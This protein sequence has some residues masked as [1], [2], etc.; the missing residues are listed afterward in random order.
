[1]G[2]VK[3]IVPHK[4]ELVMAETNWGFYG[5]NNSSTSFSLLK[6]SFCKKRNSYFVLI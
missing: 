2:K 3:K 6:L 1:V 4:I 5:D